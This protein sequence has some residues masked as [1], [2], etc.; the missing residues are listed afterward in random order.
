M[1]LPD[2]VCLIAR[3]EQASLPGCLG[4]KVKGD[5]RLFLS[6]LAIKYDVPV[7]FSRCRSG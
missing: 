6:G 4:L 1:R 5:I 7:S 2:S 3:N